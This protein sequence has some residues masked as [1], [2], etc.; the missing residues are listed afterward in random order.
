MI[1][2]HLHL[3]GSL[4]A[5]EIFI[6]AKQQH[7][8][9]PSQSI[10]ELASMLSVSS[11]CQDLNEYLQT[12]ELPLLVLQTK[13]ALTFAFSHL[14]ARLKNQGLSYVEIRFAPQLHTRQKLSQ[15][16]VVESAVYA[17]HQSLLQYQ[18]EI[19]A[20]LILCCMRGENNLKQN[21]ET[22]EVAKAFLG[23]GVCALD[24]AGAEG[25]YKTALFKPIFERAAAEGIPY[26][27]HAGE[28]DGPESIWEAIS[29]GAS[30][31]GHGVQ[32][33]KDE[34]LMDYLAEKQ[35]PLEL[36]FSSNLQTRAIAS[37]KQFPLQTFLK[38]GILATINTDNMT[39][40]RTTLKHEYN[41]LQQTFLLSPE[42]NHQLQLNA[43]KAAFLTSVEKD[44]LLK[45]S[46]CPPS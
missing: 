16:D 43:I 42:Q 6:L 38:R 27:I 46:F 19:H 33:I 7:L 44:M 9:L 14:L 3:D 25:L 29:M 36:C 1:D 4:T 31:I 28:A 13:E 21:L 5:E 10:D 23:Q 2:L 15:Y 24:L 17:L 37:A 34:K 12:F 39:V 11:N 45:N 22:V 41:L 30:R 20:Q 26:T 32:S 40:S 8:T 18:G 35:M